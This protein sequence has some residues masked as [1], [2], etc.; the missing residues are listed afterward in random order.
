MATTTAKVFDTTR[1]EALKEPPAG[2]AAPAAASSA[3]AWSLSASQTA[4]LEQIGIHFTTAD[5][6]ETKVA[7]SSESRLMELVRVA[8][9]GRAHPHK[10][11]LCVRT[12][13]QM[14]V[15]KTAAQC[16]HA[17]VDGVERCR[18]DPQHSRG[19]ETWKLQGGR[20]IVVALDDELHLTQLEAAA[21]KA[22]LPVHV[23]EDAGLT[24]V[25]MG[26]QTV[27]AIGPAPN[28]AIDPLTSSLPLL[29]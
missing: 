26:T 27:L 21:R 23:V 1:L 7:E 3:R 24:E 16:A 20:Q 19:Y 9:A 6:G 28:A 5:D 13:L 25:E 2:T 29:K 14:S 12:D 22:K 4:K 10:M 8:R 18:A 17:A 15:G 11:V